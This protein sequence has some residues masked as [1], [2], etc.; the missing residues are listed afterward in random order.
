MWEIPEIKGTL[1]LT[2]DGKDAAPQGPTAPKGFTV[3]ALRTSPHTLKMTTKVNGDPVNR[4][5]M[6]LSA[7]GKKITEVGSPAKV[8]EPYTVVWVK[9]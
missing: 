1:D 2:L 7:D 3:A 9:Q 4:S 6:T 8:N 5:T